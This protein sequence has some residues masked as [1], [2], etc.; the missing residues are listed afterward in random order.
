MQGKIKTSIITASYNSEKTIESVLNQ[1][2]NSFEYIIV[3][4]IGKPLEGL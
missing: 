4:G 2:I 1:S 3:D